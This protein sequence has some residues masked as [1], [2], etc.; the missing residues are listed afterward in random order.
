MT[1]RS[2]SRFWGESQEAGWFACVNALRLLDLEC[3]TGEFSEHRKDS[4][5]FVPVTALNYT[6]FDTSFV[7][8]QVQKEK[9][10]IE[11]V[12]SRLNALV[13]PSDEPID[14]TAL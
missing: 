6:V 9:V 11:E 1:G 12:T 2:S 7:A 10:L 4:Y 5:R 3:F 13:P 8:D 14:S